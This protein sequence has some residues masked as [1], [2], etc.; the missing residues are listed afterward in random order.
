M[1]R[2]VQ[3]HRRDEE[4]HIKYLRHQIITFRLAQSKLILVLL[5]VRQDPSQ[6][7][8]LYAVLDGADRGRAGS[9]VELTRNVL[10]NATKAPR[11]SVYIDS[12]M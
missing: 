11:K 9:R 4:A 8:E 12:W 6:H 1:R 2:V 5:T 3:Y 10:V 7:V